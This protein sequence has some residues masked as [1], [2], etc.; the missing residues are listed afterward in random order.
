MGR[1]KKRPTKVIGFRIP[2][3]NYDIIKEWARRTNKSLT[4]AWKDLI[5]LGRI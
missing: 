4:Q 5:K 2:K 3:E 1:K